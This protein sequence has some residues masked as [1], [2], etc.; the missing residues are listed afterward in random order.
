LTGDVLPAAVKSTD[1]EG[2]LDRNGPNTTIPP[3][4]VSWAY[5]ICDIASTASAPIIV[6]FFM[7]LHFL[8]LRLRPK[9][10]LDKEDATRPPRNRPA[11][12]PSILRKPMR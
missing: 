8:I 3:F 6:L 1:A 7:P 12:R 5:P 11:R 4:T 10:P 2:P 9:P